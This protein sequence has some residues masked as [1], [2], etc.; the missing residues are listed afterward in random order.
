MLTVKRV[1]NLSEF[2]GLQESWKNLIVSCGINTTFL[3][4]EWLYTWWTHFGIDKELCLILVIDDGDLVGIAPLMAIKTQKRG[5]IIQKLCSMAN[6]DTDV[7]GFIIPC[8]R[9]EILQHIC[10]YITSIKN[11]WDVL[12]LSDIPR[13]CLDP[14]LLQCFFPNEDY[15]F[16]C[17]PSIHLCIKTNCNWNGYKTEISSNFKR[18]IKRRKNM[19]LEDGIQYSIS[20]L[21][22]SEI[23]S[24]HM[25]II[26]DIQAKSRYPDSYESNKEKSFHKDLVA[27]TSL[28][29]WP[30]IS[31]I[32]FNGI[33]AA[34]EYGFIYNNRFEFWHSGF[35]TQFD[36]Y[37]PG[38]ILL[39]D[40]VET[41]CSK[42]VIELDMLRG[43][44][45]YKR[46]WNGKEQCYHHLQFIKRKSL[47]GMI[48][49]AWL[50]GIKRQLE[51]RAL[52]N[53]HANNN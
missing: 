38:N 11:Q 14:S 50:P 21:R 27:I 25:E 18:N 4:W 12:E 8:G 42:G 36:Q 24:E 22:N 31:I 32:Y 3:T 44:E 34:Y 37:T 39:L 26:F 7:S 23:H 15:Y 30:V 28:R 20:H 29:G 2:A 45:G 47:K 48:L 51:K 49:Y 9:P 33:P 52:K 10:A 5:V 43:D 35:D 6:H 40:M 13:D 53:Y 46:K 19:L 17:R 1:D 41:Y 16:L